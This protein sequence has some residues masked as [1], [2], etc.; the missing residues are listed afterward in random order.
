MFAD[1]FDLLT[2]TIGFAFPLVCLFEGMR[3]IGASGVSRN[4]VVLAVFGLVFLAPHIGYGYWAHQFQIQTLETVRK[5]VTIPELP[6]NWGVDFPPEKRNQGSVELARA[7]FIEH[8]RLYRYF[9]QSG[10]RLVFAP[11]YADLQEREA[12]VAGL[13]K[14]EASAENTERWPLR[15]AL[16]TCLVALFGFGFGRTG[17]K[18]ANP[19]LNTD[20]PPNGGAPVS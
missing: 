11:T 17:T 19:P 7:A 3:R 20:A 18:V 1:L 16:S 14:L 2:S 8:G 13:A 12:K 4:S 15:L 10:E 6:D 9:T 5:G